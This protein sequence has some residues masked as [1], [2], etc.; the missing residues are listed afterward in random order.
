[1]AGFLEDCASHSSPSQK[2]VLF[3]GL[4]HPMSWFTHGSCSET[5]WM[6]RI[7]E[8]DGST[9]RPML[10]IP[11]LDA[12]SCPYVP[13]WAPMGYPTYAF[14]FK[15]LESG[16]KAHMHASSVEMLAEEYVT[17]IKDELQKLD[18]DTF[19]MFG[20]NF[21]V[22]VAKF[23]AVCARR[24]NLLPGKL[25]AIDPV[26]PSIQAVDRIVPSTIH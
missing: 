7:L 11:S 13:S 20:A 14:K 22:M 26:P 2:R 24:R 17:L 21:G 3:G 19:H 8:G 25:I 1:L 23:I 4:E 16:N 9:N 15:Y 6:T 10:G 12:D 18:A 5:L